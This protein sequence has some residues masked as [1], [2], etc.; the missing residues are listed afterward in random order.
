MDFVSVTIH[1]DSA[2]MSG[3][4]TSQESAKRWIV[5]T[6]GAWLSES[7]LLASSR[8]EIRRTG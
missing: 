4:F 6:L 2:Q 7:D 1:F 3:N 8:I 5:D